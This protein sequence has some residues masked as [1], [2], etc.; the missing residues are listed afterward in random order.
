MDRIFIILKKGKP[1]KVFI[2]PCTGV[3]YHNIQTCLLVYAADS[4]ERLQ[5]HWSSGFH[6]PQVPTTLMPETKFYL[7]LS[8]GGVTQP[9]KELVV[10]TVPNLIFVQTDRGIY[11]PSTAHE[12]IKGEFIN[13][14]LV[15][16]GLCRTCLENTLLVFPFVTF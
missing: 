4:G 12:D 6:A 1:P 14:V 2:S 9:S 7:F 15:Q 11:K 5:D 3:K 10:A 8:A 13:I 16:L